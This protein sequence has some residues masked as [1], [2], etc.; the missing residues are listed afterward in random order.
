LTG[1]ADNILPQVL[2]DYITSS[3]VK[4]KKCQENK[5]YWNDNKQKCKDAGYYYNR[6]NRSNDKNDQQCKRWKK[7]DYEKY[8]KNCKNILADF[9]TNYGDAEL[10]FDILTAGRDNEDVQ[11]DDIQDDNFQDEDSKDDLEEIQDE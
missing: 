4:K 7:H 9:F 6:G 1:T 2:S 8:E 10:I 11:D 3:G 5:N